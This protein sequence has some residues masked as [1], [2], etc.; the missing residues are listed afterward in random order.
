MKHCH[1]QTYEHTISV[2]VPAFYSEE[3]RKSKKTIGIDRCVL[4]EIQYL[5][6]I[7]IRT[8]GSCC[9][10]GIKVAMVNV[11]TD[12]MQRMIQMDYIGGINK[13]GCPT[14]ALKTQMGCGYN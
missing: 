4:K 9:G 13:H 12:D 10:H 3:V 7:G 6:S 14:F 11:H 2:F 8:Y 1:I 5:W